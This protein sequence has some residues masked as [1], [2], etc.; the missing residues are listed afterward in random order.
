MKILHTVVD[1]WL[2]EAAINMFKTL[3]VENEFVFLRSS[4][5]NGNFNVL[6]SVEVVKVVEIGSSEYRELLTPGRFDLLWIHGLYPSAAILALDLPRHVKVMWTSW[7]FDYLRFNVQWMYA[8]KTTWY[9]LKTTPKR[10]VARCLE[11]Y[12]LSRSGLMK[13]AYGV[14]RRENLF[15]RLFPKIDYF[16]TVLPTEEKYIRRLLGPKPVKVRFHCTSPKAK[17]RKY[18]IANLHSNRILLGNSADVTCNHLDMFPLVS[19]VG[20]E[21]WSP[22]SYSRTSG[23]GV[24]TYAEDVIREGKRLMGDKFH[25]I[26][27]MLPGEEYVKLVASCPIC[28]FDHY[29]QQGVGSSNLALKCGCC[30]FLNPRNPAYEYYLDNGI[31]VYP[32]DRLKSSL[33]EVLEEFRPHQAENAEAALALAGADHL[34]SENAATVQFLRAEVCGEKAS[35]Q[36]QL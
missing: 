2:S 16:S 31:R 34:I 20:Y 9:W 6:K 11:G 12:L 35:P 32:V 5:W 18:P 4:S 3:P 25:P 28:V 27:E 23:I 29:R 26:M 13:S 21:A 22:L 15:F 19:K 17:G 36:L 14:F 24:S 8:P 1:W 7:G 10:E 33:V 30:V